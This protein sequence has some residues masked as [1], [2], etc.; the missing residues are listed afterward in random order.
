MWSVCHKATRLRALAASQWIRRVEDPGHAEKHPAREPE[1]PV[2]V[3]GATRWAGGRTRGAVSP[4]S[5]AIGSHTAHSTDEAAEQKRGIAGALCVR[6]PVRRFM[7]QVRP[8]A[9]RRVP[10][11]TKELIAELNPVLRE[12]G[13]YYKRAPVRGP[14]EGYSTNS[15][16]GWC[17]GYAGIGANAAGRWPAPRQLSAPPPTRHLGG[18]VMRAEERALTSGVL[19]KKGRSGD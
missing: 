10:L 11:Q 8:L 16:V 17:S 19:V 2:V 5:T 18:R 14:S 7:D 1:D 12:W 3:H 15:T 6:N 13:H 4:S 9:R